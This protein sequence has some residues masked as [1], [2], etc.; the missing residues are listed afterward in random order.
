MPL[1]RPKHVKPLLTTL[2]SQISS[3]PKLFNS[4]KKVN[5]STTLIAKIET[6][7]DAPNIVEH[8]HEKNTS[9]QAELQFMTS[10]IAKTFIKKVQE[11][12]LSDETFQEYSETHRREIEEEST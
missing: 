3:H 7:Q 2:D 1:P 12:L 9:I 11:M 5:D 6:F 10:T 4:Q 8:Q